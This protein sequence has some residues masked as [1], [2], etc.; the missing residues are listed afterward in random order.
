M[1]PIALLFALLALASLACMT[2]VPTQTAPVPTATPRPT[3]VLVEYSE[4]AALLAETCT[5]T[6]QTDTNLRSCAS[7]GCDNTGDW[8]LK[9]ETISAVCNQL[10]AYVPKRGWVCVPAMTGTG[11]CH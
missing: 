8:I 7:V 5:L 10:W 3:P 9:G 6:A 4:P 11:Y 1:K 2:A